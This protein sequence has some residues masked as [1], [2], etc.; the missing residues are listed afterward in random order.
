MGKDIVNESNTWCFV[1]EYFDRFWK[2]SKD[3]A[4]MAWKNNTPHRRKRK[5]C[6]SLLESIALPSSINKAD[7]T[8][9]AHDLNRMQIW[10]ERHGV[11]QLRQRFRCEA[12]E[13]GHGD[14]SGLAEVN[15]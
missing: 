3:G 2:A 11:C 7:C 14:N 8:P 12:E 9:T 13:D 5:T 4:Q 6:E 1:H 15:R 10:H